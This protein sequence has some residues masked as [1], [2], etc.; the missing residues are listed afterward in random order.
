[1]QK[2]SDPFDIDKIR[3]WIADALA[4][5]GGTHEVEDVL[6]GIRSGRMQL[7]PAKRGCAVT[8]II[9]FPRK[10]VL[11]VFL[12][13]GEM[14]QILDMLESAKEWGR[15]QG[16]TGFTIAG[17]KGWKRVLAKHGFVETM[18]LLEARI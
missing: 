7:W 16:C 4:Y 13:A 6:E 11:H 12:A 17:R 14:D 15:Q 1:M 9:E 3:G 8:E 2:M 5:S 10:R 18:T